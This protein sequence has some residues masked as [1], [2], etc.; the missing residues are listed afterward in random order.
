MIGR[1]PKVLTVIRAELRKAFG[2]DPDCL[3]FT[4]SKRPSEAGKVDSLTD[5]ALMLL[6][7]PVVMAN[8]NQFTALSVKGDPGCRLPYTP[9]EALQRVNALRLFERLDHAVSEYW[10]TLAQGSWLTRQER[11]VEL[12]KT[13]FADRAFMARQLEEL[14]SAGMALV[15]ALIDAP[16]A[17]ARERAG[18]EW[19]SVKVSQLMWPGTPAVAMPG[20]LHLYREGEASD[21]PHVIYLPGTARNFYEAPS[22]FALQCTCW[23]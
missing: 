14:S 3:L 20:A 1:S 5:R 2:M 9:L 23:R 15:Q 19:A 18:G 22:F 11:W 6:A 16:A 10:G 13:L 12:Q 17:E 21:T 8:V 7:L 4:E